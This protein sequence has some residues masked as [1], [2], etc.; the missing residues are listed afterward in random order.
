LQLIEDW[1][2]EVVASRRDDN[3]P[4]DQTLVTMIWAIAVAIFC[5]GGMLGGCITGLVADKF[6]RKGGLLLNNVLVFLAAILMVPT[7]L[8]FLF[9]SVFNSFL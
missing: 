8:A 5:V 6:G 7:L 4:V 1:I 3:E 2:R 9:H